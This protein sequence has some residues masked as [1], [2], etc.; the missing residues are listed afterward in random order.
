GLMNALALVLLLFGLLALGLSALLVATM[1]SAILA[2]HVRQIGAMKAIGAQQTQVGLM[3][4]AMVLAIGGAAALLAI[5]PGV[6]A[7]REVAGVYAGLSNVELDSLAIAPWV[8][9]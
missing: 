2:R 3:Y 6:V 4:G 9:A 7:G 1:V 5:L 8:F